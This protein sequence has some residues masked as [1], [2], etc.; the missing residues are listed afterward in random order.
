MKAVDT[1]LGRLPKWALTAICLVIVCYIG[2]WGAVAIFSERDVEFFPPKIGSG[3]K[4]KLVIEFSEMRKDIKEINKL[5]DSHIDK[6]YDQL[7]EARNK[8]S[9][10]KNTSDS[11]N[12]QTNQYDI[13]RDIE[14]YEK[15]ISQ[16]IK[17][18]TFLIKE[19]ETKLLGL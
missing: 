10:A 16:E 6:L 19:T 3:P 5:M 17:D 14:K 7:N 18:L 12:W 15:E 2:M 8:E 11:I 4:T 9:T 1:A 13:Q